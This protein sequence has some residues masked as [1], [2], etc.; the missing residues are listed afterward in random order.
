VKHLDLCLYHNR[1]TLKLINLCYNKSLLVCS[2][3]ALAHFSPKSCDPAAG[4]NSQGIG[5]MVL[6][7]QSG[8]SG[9]VLDIQGAVDLW[10]STLQGLT[11]WVTLVVFSSCMIH[12]IIHLST[13]GCTTRYWWSLLVCHYC[14]VFIHD[15][16]S[17]ASPGTRPTVLALL[18]VLGGLALLG[19][20]E[21]LGCL[22]RVGSWHRGWSWWP[23][24]YLPPRRKTGVFLLI[25]STEVGQS[26]L[27]P[28]LFVLVVLSTPH[29]GFLGVQ[30]VGDW[31]S[32]HCTQGWRWCSQCCEW[33][34]VRHWSWLRVLVYRCQ[35]M[36]CV[37]WWVTW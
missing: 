1:G 16:H 14:W 15:M 32:L 29:L 7:G 28:I 33:G 8:R 36:L 2:S 5:A 9:V 25:G 20:L 11:V 34:L 24:C 13:I 10:F 17:F 4:H 35:S 18:C 27:T 31:K 22:D 3:C 37:G 12:D 30:A 6:M 19:C 23:N 26:W 21:G